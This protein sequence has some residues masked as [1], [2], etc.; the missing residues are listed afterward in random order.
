MIEV[1]RHLGAGLLESAY[2]ACVCRE[3][4]MRR[5]RFARQRPMP[6]T[7]K[8]ISLECGYRIDLVVDE[9]VLVELKAVDALLPIHIAQVIT[10][11][12]LSQMPVGLLVNFN[13]PVLKQ[14]LRRL[15]LSTD[16]SPDPLPVPSSPFENGA[17]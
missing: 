12:R 3:L 6:L 7:Y 8:G 5:L 17:R 11:L 16:S 1:H 2:E 15:W 10:Y 4:T 14:G 13:V 9:C